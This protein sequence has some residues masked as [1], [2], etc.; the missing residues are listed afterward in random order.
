MTISAPHTLRSGR[1]G[2]QP[3]CRKLVHHSCSMQHAAHSW[4]HAA[5]ARM[6]SIGLRPKGAGTALQGCDCCAE[7]STWSLQRSK[8]AARGC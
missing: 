6:H 7:T 1:A 2:K 8:A 4:Q 5:T 3:V